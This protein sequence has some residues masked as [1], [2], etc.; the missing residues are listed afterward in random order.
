MSVGKLALATAGVAAAT[1]LSAAEPDAWSLLKEIEITEHVTETEYEV[2]K[3]YPP[4]LAEGREI[5]IEITGYA[6]PALPGEM[7]QD[8]LMV[9][10][11][12]LCPFCGSLEHGATLAVSLAEPIP[13]IDDQTR[14]TLRGTLSPV[15]DP[16]TWQ[17]V[18][19]K[20]AQ[21]IRN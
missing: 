3:S 10:D 11:M 2:R 7:I 6:T 14:L 9:S 15:T 20:N 17:S 4:A 18:V 19:L 8:L 1:T 12:G 5:E 13:V 21:I 16:E